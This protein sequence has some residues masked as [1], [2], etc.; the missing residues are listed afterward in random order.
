MRVIGVS[1]R[2]NVFFSKTQPN[3][4]MFCISNSE[5]QPLIP[6]QTTHYTKLTNNLTGHCFSISFINQYAFAEQICICDV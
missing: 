6:K 1:Q 2:Q 3:N 4:E 5:Y